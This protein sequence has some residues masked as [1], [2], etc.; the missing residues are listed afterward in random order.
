MKRSAPVLQ[1]WVFLAAATALLL[2]SCTDGGKTT[3]GESSETGNNGSDVSSV[4]VEGNLK[5]LTRNS[6]SLERGGPLENSNVMYL[7][8]EAKNHAL[9]TPLS[10]DV[11]PGNESA[12]SSSGSL[13]AG[14][15]VSS[16][17]LHFDSSGDDDTALSG[18]IRLPEPVVGIIA[19]GPKL[20]ESDKR[21]GA[22]N[23]TYPKPDQGRWRGINLGDRDEVSLSSDRRRIEVDLNNWDG[24]D[25]MRILTASQ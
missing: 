24:T 2:A 17:V 21:L 25:Q 16:Y 4:S 18:T 22:S 1:R 9:Q 14:T 3:R 23:V 6:I 12:S 13:P 20:D 5:V 10:I 8:P 11:R 15:V 7:I 19:A